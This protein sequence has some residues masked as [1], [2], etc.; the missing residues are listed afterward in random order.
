MNTDTLVDKKYVEAALSEINRCNILEKH[1][2]FSNIDEYDP[3]TLGNILIPFYYAVKYWTQHLEMFSNCLINSNDNTSADLVKENI[4]DESGNINGK[5]IYSKKHII[6]YI[7][8][9]LALNY[10]TTLRKSPAV[11]KFIDSLKNILETKPFS[12]NA[13]VLGGIEHFYIQISTT[14]KTYCD[15]NNIR[16]EHYNVHEI[17]DQK[18]AMDF[19]MVAINQKITREQLFSGIH[20][21]YKL[22]WDVYEELVS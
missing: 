11:D 7:N 5:I 14:F 8:F 1:L 15:K 18:H 16:Q 21:G 3:K 22:L 4:D 12:Y 20:E 10:N 13:A 2:L 17:L 6:T 19:F 9:L